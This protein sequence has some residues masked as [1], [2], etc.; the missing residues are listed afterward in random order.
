MVALVIGIAS[1]AAAQTLPKLPRDYVF[2]QGDG[3]PGTV[4]FS[5]STHVDQQKPACTGCHPVLFRILQ[6]GTPV[7]G[8]R[9]VHAAMEAKRQC[10]ACHDDAAPPVPERPRAFGLG[11]CDMCHRSE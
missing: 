11:Q 9:I 7:D 8:G 10:G 2:P 6:S 3:S 4:T 1:A 5:H